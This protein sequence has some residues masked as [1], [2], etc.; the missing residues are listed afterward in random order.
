MAQQLKAFKA[1][2]VLL[3]EKFFDR[4]NCALNSNW[5]IVLKT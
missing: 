4:K 2:K 1:I 5:K 3:I